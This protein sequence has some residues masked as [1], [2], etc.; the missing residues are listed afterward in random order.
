M[1]RTVTYM[2]RTYNHERFVR[3]AVRSA[4][5]QDYHPLQ[6]VITDDASSDR[7]YDNIVEEVRQYS[8]PHEILVN[9][10][11][12]RMRSIEALTH[13]MSMAQGEFVVMAHGDDVSLPHRT[14]ALV[15]A[16]REHGVSMVS[17]NAQFIDRRGT[18]YNLTCPNSVSRRISAEDIL[19]WNWLWEML[20]ATVG[21]E[22]EVLTKFEPL[23]ARSLAT[24]ADYVLPMRAT[25]LKGFYFVEQPLVQYR[26]HAT[27]MGNFIEDRTTTRLARDETA[28]ANYVISRVR[29][30]D[31]L[32]VL[33]AEQPGNAV[34]KKLRKR[35]EAQLLIDLRRWCRLRT[36][37]CASAQ[38]PTWVAEKRM[39]ARRLRPELSIWYGKEPFGVKATRWL[40]S[41]PA[42]RLVK[43]FRWFSKNVWRGDPMRRW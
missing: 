42:W 5:A 2:L 41:T 3:E 27:N 16:W 11:T 43:L 36:E 15:S 1:T 21:Y 40:N 26:R 7:T 14:A 38:L 30:L 12:H 23:T 32:P 10:N 29:V 6:I 37:L 35:L 18:K 34:L 20:G 19:K 22:P 31:D 9:R 4:F 13:A 39:L 28:I 24:G 17:S 33:E 25:M 8:G